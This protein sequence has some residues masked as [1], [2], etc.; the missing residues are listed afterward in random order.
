MTALANGATISDYKRGYIQCTCSRTN[1]KHKANE[2]KEL[3][4]AVLMCTCTL[5]S[6][7]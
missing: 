1:E 2:A 3:V 4:I 5:L 7:Q 6:R